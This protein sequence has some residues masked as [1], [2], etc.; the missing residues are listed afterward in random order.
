MSS[1]WMNNLKLFIILFTCFTI[2][3]LL[4]YPEYKNGYQLGSYHERTAFLPITRNR[5]FLEAAEEWKKCFA[6]KLKKSRVEPKEMWYWVKRATN[7]C[8][9]ET[10]FSKID[11]TG[12][13][14]KDEMKYHVYSPSQEPSVVVTLGI[15]LDV[16]AETTLKNTL[17]FGSRFFAADPIF[18]GNG[19]LYEPVGSYFPF[20]V[21]KETDVSTAL[22]LKNGRYINQVMPHIDI[23]TF[24]T[25]FVKESTIDQFL[26][27]NE[28]PEYDILPMMARGAEFDQNG[29]V[30]CQ[31]NTEV[32]QADDERKKKFL[33]IMNTIIED[34]RYAFM[35]AYATVH[36]RFFII[37]MEH[38]IC[39]EKYFARFFE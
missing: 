10:S 1:R 30:V 31:M 9:N 4:F 35:V 23:I 29:I 13:K 11:L 16:K 18:K 33:G 20:A 25:K 34:G 14:N 21:G 5:K 3:F 6:E 12:V 28:G 17:P 22:V 32:H 8:R 36:H 26:M 38:P 2:F 39:V 7:V 19:E 37:N 15:G 24:F 27:D